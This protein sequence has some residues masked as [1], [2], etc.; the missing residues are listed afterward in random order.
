MPQTTQRKREAFLFKMCPLCLVRVATRSRE[1]SP[2]QSR[3]NMRGALAELRGVE[4]S[5][6]G[7]PLE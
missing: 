2:G 7:S 5:N 1:L 3:G 4:D 6:Q